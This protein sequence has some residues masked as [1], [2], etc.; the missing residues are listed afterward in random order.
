MQLTYTDATYLFNSNIPQ[1]KVL[2]YAVMSVVMG[3]SQNRPLSTKSRVTTAD[4]FA[5]FDV[6]FSFGA[7]WPASADTASEPVIV[8]S[9]ALNDRLFG[10]V[11]SVG[12]VTTN[13]AI[14]LG[15]LTTFGAVKLGSATALTDSA[16]A[17]TFVNAAL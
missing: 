13:G 15:Q 9:H 12:A 10:G 11:N 6:P 3:G 8:L 5:M 7:A 2:T 16:G 1:R 4:F 14:V 17:V